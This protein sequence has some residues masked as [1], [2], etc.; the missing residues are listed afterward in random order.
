MSYLEVISKLEELVCVRLSSC[1]YGSKEEML[2]SLRSDVL[3]SNVLESNVL[4]S[5]RSDVLESNVLESNVL[6][7]NVLESN[8]LESNVLESNVLESN[9]LESSKCVSLKN[10]P[11]CGKE[12]AG[13]CIGLK[14]AL[15]LYTQC[16]KECSGE[17]CVGCLK[18]L[19]INGGKSPYGTVY[20][21][22]KCGIM[23]YK[24]PQ[25]KSPIAFTKIMKK[26]NLSREEVE[27][28]GKRLGISIPECHFEEKIEKRGR[29]KKDTS[30]EDTA[31]EK[32]DVAPVSS[33]EK[34]KR[35]R[36]KKEKEIISNN[37]GEDLI[38]SLMKDTQNTI[39]T[40]LE[41]KLETELETELEEEEEETSVIKFEINGTTYLKS[42]DHIL[43]DMNSHEGI[44]IW[45]EETKEIEK[46][47]DDED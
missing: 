9:V 4:K 43:Y 14:K 3:E 1:G 15:G 6:E 8:V 11:W 39:E 28:E 5:L 31:S 33:A 37:A 36:P 26:L 12:K 24:D 22:M 21:R 20:D 46:L 47:P 45:N 10:M 44:G 42:D 30:T 38:A 23:E 41:P 17:Y 19:E 18:S 34:K 29:P 25:G 7:S 2:K 13:C 40:E 16:K 27:L 32:S 35:G